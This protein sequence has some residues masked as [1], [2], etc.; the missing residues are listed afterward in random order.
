ME[1][2]LEEVA[3][4]NAGCRLGKAPVRDRALDAVLLNQTLLLISSSGPEKQES[5]SPTPEKDTHTVLVPSISKK[6]SCL[7][8]FPFSVGLS[9][10]LRC[11]VGTQL[12]YHALQVGILKESEVIEI[13]EFSK[14]CYVLITAKMQ[15]NIYFVQ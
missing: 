5:R 9:A 13:R 1:W 6:S 3:V 4:K 7:L 10:N 14:I 11:I 12:R 8:T 2:R 15:V